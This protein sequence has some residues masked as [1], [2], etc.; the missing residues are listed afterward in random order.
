[1]LQNGKKNII[2]ESGMNIKIWS[3]NWPFLF[4]Y[5]FNNL[6]DYISNNSSVKILKTF[7]N[8]LMYKASMNDLGQLLLLLRYTNAYVEFTIKTPQKLRRL[9]SRQFQTNIALT[10]IVFSKRQLT[11]TRSHL[12]L[13][14]V[15]TSQ[16]WLRSLL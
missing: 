11:S 4:C 3:S 14:P 12:S 5:K 13:S 10:S 9:F 15:L 7:W 16:T 1:M 2:I 8:S 6:F